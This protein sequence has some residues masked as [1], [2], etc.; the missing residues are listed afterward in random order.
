MTKEHGVRPGVGVIAH[1]GASAYAPENTL[2]SFRQAVEMKADW[3]ELDCTLTRDGE[4]IVIHDDKVDRTTN[5]KGAVRTLSLEE[6]KKLDAGSWK[7]PQFAGERLPTLGEA[8]DTA[9]GHTGVYI[10][11][12]DSGEDAQLQAQIM[13]LVKDQTTLT[14]QLRSQVQKLIEASGTPNLE[15]TRKVIALVRDRHM[16]RKVVIQSFSPIVC[17]VALAEAP[18]IR[19]EILGGDDKK[20]PA[21]WEGFLRWGYLLGVAGFNPH[22]EAITPGRL[23]AF[24]AAGKTVSVWTVD[25]EEDMQRL[26]QW[27]V[28]NI[29]TNRPDV[30]RKV[31]SETLPQRR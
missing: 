6:I 16:Q 10:E 15:L 21:M 23:A 26:A 8:L 3:F 9:Q 1:R 28:D 5:G 14:P 18:D 31:L 12:K 19:V 30:C 27:G 24:H 17:A 22:A 2:A 11:I 7:D 29:I 4:V 25:K 13:D 20:K